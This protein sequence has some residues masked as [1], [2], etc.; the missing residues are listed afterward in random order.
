MSIRPSTEFTLDSSAQRA[1]K[2]YSA[3]LYSRNIVVVTF[4]MAPLDLP[5]PP[6]LHGCSLL[7]HLLSSSRASPSSRLSPLSIFTLY[8]F[9][10]LDSIQ[11]PTHTTLHSLIFSVCCAAPSSTSDAPQVRA[12]G[13]FARAN[14][15]AHLHGSRLHALTT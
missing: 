6:P 11:F 12:R 8:P 5:A 10:S 2:A 1:G 3:F 7:V 4:R 14:F 15:F 9:R 13:G